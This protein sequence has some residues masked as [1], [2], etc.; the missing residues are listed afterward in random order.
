[1]RAVIFANGAVRHPD[2][3]RRQVR[4]DDLL[5]AADGG[6]HHLQ[7][8]GLTPRVV[9]GDFD[10]LDPGE[11]RSLERAGVGLV[12]HPARKDATDLDLALEYARDQG[13]QQAVV[14]G[15]VG[16]RWDQSLANLLMIAAGRHQGLQVRLVDGPQEAQLVRPGEPLDIEGQPGDTLSL[17]PLAGDAGGIT[18]QGLEYPLEDSTL[19]FG[20]S[21]GV[22]NSLV[23]KRGSV[24]LREGLLMCIVIHGPL[25]TIESRARFPTG[26]EKEE[27]HAP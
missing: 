23:S 20:S 2:H 16:G 5:I 14:L 8:L 9:I 17:I 12:Q 27:P 1:M 3:A 22:S 11:L 4:S 7:D 25:E 26:S 10:S 13:A 24:A 21:R 6:L 19:R 15:A 18:T